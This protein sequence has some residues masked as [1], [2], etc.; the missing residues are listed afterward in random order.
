[1]RTPVIFLATGAMLIIG[2]PAQAAGWTTVASPS[3]VPGDNYLYGADSSGASNVWAVGVVYPP[4]GG[5]SHSLALRYDGTAWRPVPRTGLPSDDTLRGVD[6]VSTGDVW[7]V[8]EHR[9]GIGRYETMAAHWN[10]T[11]WTREPTPNGNPDGMNHVYGVA[12]AG[13]TVWAVGNYADPSS[14]AN[15]RK[16]I[17]QRAGGAW[18]VSAAP[19]RATYES[20]A[21]V[22]ATGPGDA[23]AV[24]SATTDIASAP[25]TPLTL[26]WNGTS[27]VSMTLPAPAGTALTGVDARTPSDVW[28][29]G[30]TSGAQPYVA[31]FDGTSWRRVTTPAIGGELTDVVALSPST[32]VAVG[33][34]NGAPLILRWN[35]TSWIRESTPASSNP[36]LTGAAA[37]G[38]GSVWA[39]GYRFELNAYANRTLTLLGS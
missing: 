2:S 5:S 8:G 15:R 33:R 39:I 16:L 22:D 18:R 25:L 36:F 17:L 28:A 38:P 3:E 9:A 30:S 19:A 29:V 6:A 7:V 35:G 23:W 14:P 32:A 24:G 10:G 20:L 11:T 26:H 21:A 31:H 37:A 1:M 12:A 34:S 13:G 27:W 4:T